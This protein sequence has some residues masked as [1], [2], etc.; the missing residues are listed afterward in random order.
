MRRL[1]HA[2]GASGFALIVLLPYGQ[3][4]AA[5][6]EII[7]YAEVI[8]GSHLTIGRNRIVLFGIEAPAAPETCRGEAGTSYACGA[9]AARVLR[10]VIGDDEVTCEPQ[11]AAATDRIIAVCRVGPI[12]LNRM[13]VAQ[14]WA[15]ADRGASDAYVSA[16][17][18]ARQAHLGLWSGR[19]EVPVEWQPRS[20]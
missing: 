5:P 17:A 12:E 9:A 14:G 16:E 1:M 7:G 20:R 18:T 19:F 2:F 11:G 8:D 4:V 6:A 15:A 3:A 13:M 10:Q